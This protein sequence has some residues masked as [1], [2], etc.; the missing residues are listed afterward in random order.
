MEYEMHTSYILTSTGPN[1][2]CEEYFLY[3]CLLLKMMKTTARIR[4]IKRTVGTRITAISSRIDRFVEE[5]EI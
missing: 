5:T 2:L 3:L 4:I 1:L